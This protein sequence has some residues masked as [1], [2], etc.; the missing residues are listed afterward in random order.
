[1]AKLQKEVL[2]VDEEEPVT[3]GIIAWMFIGALVLGAVGPVTLPPSGEPPDWHAHV[4]AAERTYQHGH[5]AIAEKEMGLLLEEAEELEPDNAHLGFTLINLGTLYHKQGR[6]SEAGPLY[7][8]GLAI[9]Q[10]T[11]RERHPVVPAVLENW[12]SLLRETGRDLEA[13]RMEARIK[14]IKAE[15]VQSNQPK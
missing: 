12:A 9:L 6:Y 10:K 15:K 3:W 8:R 13:E 1:M 5:Y 2:A 4:R 7:R 11:C 14:V